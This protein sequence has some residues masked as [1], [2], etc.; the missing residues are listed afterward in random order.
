[1]TIPA[2]N[3]S[4][5]IGQL[6]CEIEETDRAIVDLLARRVGLA[7]RIGGEKACAGKPTLDPAH[8]ARVVRRAASFAR[9]AGLDPEI[10]R[11]LYWHLVR[12]CR[13]AQLVDR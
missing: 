5:A 1:M 3:S 10:V 11:D 4:S 8:E 6:R 13:T 9:D 2:A 12:L 7:R